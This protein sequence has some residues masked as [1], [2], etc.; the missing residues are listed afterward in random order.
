M[1]TR[2]KFVLLESDITAQRFILLE[3][4]EDEIEAEP[5]KEEDSEAADSQRILAKVAY[6]KGQLL[7]IASA[8]ESKRAALADSV[9]P[10]DEPLAD[11][12]EKHEKVRIKAEE[13]EKA[14]DAI[15]KRATDEANRFG[16]LTIEELSMKD[17]K[18]AF[19]DGQ[20]GM[21]DDLAGIFE[22]FAHIEPNV[23]DERSLDAA[24]SVCANI[25]LKIDAFSSQYTDTFEN[26][27]RRAIA[28]KERDD[29][30]MTRKSDNELKAA[31]ASVVPN[32][33]ALPKGVEEIVN[34]DAF[35]Q[36]IKTFGAKPSMNPFISFLKKAHDSNQA[37]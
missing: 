17:A 5:S 23:N 35:A 25:S 29:E 36:E 13:I 9:K 15:E 4:E 27:Q 19:E 16:A 6:V 14:L 12:A 11:A 37:V 31:I 2:E 18:A 10:E 3:G 20:E 24:K 30:E 33:E 21:D 8:A 22:L 28:D 1:E 26:R 34:G 32:T 7:K